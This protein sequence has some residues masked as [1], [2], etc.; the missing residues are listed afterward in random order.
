MH[1]YLLFA[2]DEY[3]PNGGWDDFITSR[4]TIAE[5]KALCKWSKTAAGWQLYVAH[6]DWQTD[7]F[8]GHWFHIVD[9]DTMEV[10]H[11]ETSFK[12]AMHEREKAKGATDNNTHSAGQG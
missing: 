6:K 7:S 9:R 1:R 12:I 5:L 4:P 10:I 3:H 11:E 8:S 2:G